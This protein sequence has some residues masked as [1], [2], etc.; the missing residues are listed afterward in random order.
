M[1]GSSANPTGEE[2]TNHALAGLLA[3]AGWTPENL[4]DRLNQLSTVQ[5]LGVR[6]HRRSVRRWVHAE[7][8]RSAPR[9]PREP[10]PSLV[11]HVLHERLGVPVTPEMLGWHTHHGLLYVPADHGLSQPWSP[12][13]A[14]KRWPKSWK[15]T[16]WTGDNTSR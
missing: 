2:R 3:R 7:P 11:C 9:V 8:G 12:P 14:W 16:P 6:G 10:W 15:L 13:G 5:G 1:T 4:G